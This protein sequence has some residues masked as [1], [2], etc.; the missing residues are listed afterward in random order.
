MIQIGIFLRVLRLVL[1]IVE[2]YNYIIV[3]GRGE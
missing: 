1:A 2:S 3:K